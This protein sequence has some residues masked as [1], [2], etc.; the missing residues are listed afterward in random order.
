ML[1]VADRARK[2]LENIE[3][4]DTVLAVTHRDWMW[5]AQLMLERLAEV[6]LAAVN[7]DEIHN[8]QIVEYTSINPVTGQ[9]APALLW[10][11]SIDPMA[12]DGPGTW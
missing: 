4:A 6:E 1:A 11:R 9:Q 12:A 2:F 8:A 5:A 7:T 10:K 3:G